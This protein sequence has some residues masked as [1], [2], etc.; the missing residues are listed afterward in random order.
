MKQILP[1]MAA[2]CL[3]TGCSAQ[4]APSVPSSTAPPPTAAPQTLTVYAD[5]AAL[6]ALQT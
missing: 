1:L 6:P 5:A 4:S 3:L 2:L